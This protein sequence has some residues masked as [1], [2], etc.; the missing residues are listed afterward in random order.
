MTPLGYIVLICWI[1]FVLMVTMRYG[2]RKGLVTGYLLGYLFLPQHSIPLPGIPDLSRETATSYAAIIAMLLIDRGEMARFRPHLCDLMV[3]S[4]CLLQG[5][6]AATNGDDA[7]EIV[8]A[9][10]S[11]LLL[12]GIPYF[13]GRIYFGDREGMRLLGLSFIIGI[14]IYIPLM[15]WEHR[16]SPQLHNILYGFHRWGMFE[17]RGSGYRP[18]VFLGNGLELGMFLSAATII[19]YHCWR[20]KALEKLFGVRFGYCQAALFFMTVIHRAMGALIL[21]AGGIGSLMACRMTRSKWP[22]LGLI[23][24]PILYLCTRPTHIFDPQPLVDIVASYDEE[25]AESLATRIHF[26]NVLMDRAEERQLFGWGRMGGRWRIKDEEGFDRTL[27]DGYWII[28]YGISGAAGLFTFTC[29]MGLPLI[30]AWRSIPKR[31]WMDRENAFTV[32]LITCTAL[33][34]I[35]CLANRNVVPMFYIVLG[36]L[37]S[38]SRWIRREGQIEDEDAFEDDESLSVDPTYDDRDMDL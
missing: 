17:K 32:A 19:G 1:P 36:G 35:D 28:I 22:I 21:C 3:L 24:T 38:F 26:E 31:E 2:G 33:Y 11:E 4:W 9:V 10:F 25:R 6:S 20:R 7:N 14:L 30:L 37:T 34:F 13:M 16:F 27:S 29:M 15:L 8:S 18:R 23:L 5:V 12:W